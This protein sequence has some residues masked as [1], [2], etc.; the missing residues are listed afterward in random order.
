MKE[1]DCCNRCCPIS[2]SCGQVSPKEK[3]KKALGQTG[4]TGP[5]GP[6]GPIGA[7]GPI[8][9]IGATGPTGPAGGETEVRSTTTLDAGEKARVES[10]KVG[11]KT[12]LDFYIPKGE[13]GKD[14]TINIEK[15][16]RSTQKDLRKCVIEWKITRIT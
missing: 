8:G 3:S 10:S 6:M 1:K 11:T 15:Q 16:K 13:K 7:T 4:P 14:D 9:P 5:A 2:I 12:V